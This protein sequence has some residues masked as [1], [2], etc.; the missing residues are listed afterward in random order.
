AYY[1]DVMEAVVALAVDAP[2]GPPGSSAEFLARLDPGW[3]ILA[4]S[5]GGLDDQLQMARAAARQVPDIALRFRTL[6]RRLGTGLDGPGGFADADAWCCILEGTG[7]IAVAEAQARALV[8]LLANYVARGSRSS[9]E[10]A[11]QPQVLLAVD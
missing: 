1:A 4:Y 2:G 11:A 9:K 10:P 7:E 6:F 5:A 3:L 8:D